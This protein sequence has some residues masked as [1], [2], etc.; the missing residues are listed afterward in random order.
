MNAQVVVLERVDGQEWVLL[1]LRGPDQVVAPGHL[2]SIGG[3]RE[4]DDT[5]PAH[6][7]A[8]ELRE[9]SGIIPTPAS[10]REF[11]RSKRCAWFVCRPLTRLPPTTPHECADTRWLRRRL[12]PGP[13]ALSAPHGH[14]WVRADR[15]GEIEW[16][17]FMSGV[18]ARIA[19][20]LEAIAGV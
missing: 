15:V 4:P 8:R 10:M 14:V 1:Q 2:A 5:G 17:P 3:R 9:E 12:G 6:T 11:A 13:R 7:A 18:K 20:A 16:P 19:A